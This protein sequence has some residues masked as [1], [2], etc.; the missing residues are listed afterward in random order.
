MI[1]YSQMWTLSRMFFEYW[2]TTPAP[3]I[4]ASGVFFSMPSLQLRRNICYSRSF[5]RTSNK[6]LES[7]LPTVGFFSCD[8]RVLVNSIG[9]SYFLFIHSFPR[10]GKKILSKGIAKHIRQVHEVDQR[11]ICGKESIFYTPI[12]LFTSN[13]SALFPI[14]KTV[15]HNRYTWIKD[16][17]GKVSSNIHMHK[18]Q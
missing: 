3:K 7:T 9:I 4:A 14:K 6:A 5:G 11:I 10:C 13:P 8:F 17:C 1:R 2:Q 15:L 12:T 16:L 18:Y